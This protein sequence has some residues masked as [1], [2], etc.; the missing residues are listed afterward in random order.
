MHADT[1]QVYLYVLLRCICFK[2]NGVVEWVGS[3]S[4]LYYKESEQA[5]FI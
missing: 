1:P 3:I 5:P 4:I 2:V